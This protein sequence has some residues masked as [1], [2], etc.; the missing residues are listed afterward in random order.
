MFVPEEEEDDLAEGDSK[1][2][3]DG[4]NE[5]DGNVLPELPEDEDVGDEDVGMDS[6]RDSAD[7][8]VKVVQGASTNND[9][10]DAERLAV[11]GQ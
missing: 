4:E 2:G 3:E 9:E 7:W 5:E 10:S 8:A 1:N 11:G 6:A